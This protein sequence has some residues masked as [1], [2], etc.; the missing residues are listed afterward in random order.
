MPGNRFQHTIDVVQ[1][2]LVPETQHSAAAVANDSV[3]HYGQPAPATATSMTSMRAL[4]LARHS[5]G[6]IL[7]ASSTNSVLRAGPPSAHAIGIESH[8]IRCSSSPPC[9]TYNSSLLSGEATQTPFLASSAIPSGT[10][11]PNSAQTD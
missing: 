10:A 3:R 4:L 2:L 7:S 8:F 5:S 6:L 1:D 11:S 9:A